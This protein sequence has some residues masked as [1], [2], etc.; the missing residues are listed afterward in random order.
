MQFEIEARGEVEVVRVRRGGSE[1]M[2]GFGTNQSNNTLQR[3]TLH[4]SLQ[5]TAYQI[6]LFITIHNISNYIIH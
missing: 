3:N 2:Q 4:Y 1:I 5:F 6:T